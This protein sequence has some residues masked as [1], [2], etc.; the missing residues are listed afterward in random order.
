MNA[1]VANSEISTI[2][3]TVLGSKLV[4]LRISKKDRRYASR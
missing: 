3:R 4:V 2:Q 1:L